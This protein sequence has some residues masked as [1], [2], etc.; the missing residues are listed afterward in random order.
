MSLGEENGWN[1]LAGLKPEKVCKGAGVDYDSETGLYGLKSFGWQIHISPNDKRVFC[2]EPG[3]EILLNELEEHYVLSLLW[4]LAEAKDIPLSGKLMRPDNL[5]GG[6]LFSQGTH[7]L[8]L[9]RIS[10]KYEK[11][12]E[13]FLSRGNSFG[14]EVSGYGDASIQ[15]SPFPRIPV[16]LILWEGDDEFPSRADLLFDSTSEFQMPIDILW[17]SAMMSVLIMI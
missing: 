9:D 12:I 8:P 5:K 10:A 1:K 17:S 13:G 6:Y 15:L 11:N 14:S 2:N 3:S 4:Y 7:I 16:T